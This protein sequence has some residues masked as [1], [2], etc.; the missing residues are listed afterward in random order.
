MLEFYR[1]SL[2]EAVPDCIHAVTMKQQNAPLSLSMALHTGEDK[3]HI[4]QNRQRIADAVGGDE[5]FD[6]VLANQTHSEHIHLVSEKETKGWEN[7]NSAIEDCDALISN[8]KGVILG[9]L[10][11]DCVP[12]LLYDP[13][14]KVIAA[15]HAG[16]KGTRA[17]IVVKTV[18]CM[19]EQFGCKPE[20]LLA[21]IG[22]AIGKCCYE[23]GKEVAIH[24]TDI[25][26]AC[27]KKGKKYRIDLKYINK[28]Q[29][30]QAGLISDHIELSTICTACENEHFF[31]YR[32]EEGCS[33]R[34]MSFIGISS[35]K[36]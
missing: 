22:P 6:F 20:V 15:V 28:Y 10:T 18:K 23:V 27:E 12:V 5:T 1:F 2:L 7:Q 25:E 24:F 11:A 29:L 9:I 13:V 14:K 26:N 34:F 16:W 30:L 21:C 4:L 31:S 3:T 33:G 17:E 8:Q 36:K 32:K 19:Q 35:I